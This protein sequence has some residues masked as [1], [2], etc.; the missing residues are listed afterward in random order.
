MIGIFSDPHGNVEAMMVALSVLRSKGVEN[1]YCLGDTVGYFPGPACVTRLIEDRIPVCRG[2][3]EDI[4]LQYSASIECEEIYQLQP[5]R[6]SLSKNELAEMALWPERIEVDV[7]CGRLLLLHG[8]PRDPLHAYVYPDTDPYHY[9]VS[10]YAA[11]FMGHTH[12]PFIRE[13][14]GVL[15]VNVG[16]CGL[17][18]DNG[19]F[20]SV[21]MF[22][23]VK[24]LATIVRFDIREATSHALTRCQHVHPSVIDIFTR[25]PDMKKTLHDV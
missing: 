4:L 18:R 17:P 20:G 8:S 1:V 7:S 16:S 5:T 6:C 24:R 3:H 25:P 19:S 14:D 12:R 2:S 23:T 9:S 11:V 22:D 21:C 10:G 13:Y 15:Y